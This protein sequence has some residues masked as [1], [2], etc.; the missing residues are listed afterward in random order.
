M[1]FL[2]CF[3]G[4]GFTVTAKT[5]EALDTMIREHVLSKYPDSE[6]ICYLITEI[7]DEKFSQRDIE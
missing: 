4:D 3:Q 5:K 7:D 2:G 6:K 1:M